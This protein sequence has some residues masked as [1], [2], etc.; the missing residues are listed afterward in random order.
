M[1]LLLSVLLGFIPMLLFAW[2]VYWLDRYEKEPAI[3]LGAVFLWGALVA[4]GAAFILNTLFGLGIYAFTGSESATDLTT[5]MLIAP[6]VEESVKGFAVLL[7]FL[8]FRSEFDSLLD[9]LIYA[10]VVALGFAASENAYYIYRLGFAENGMGGLIG[11][12]FVRVV[13][14][15]W[16]HPF[17]TAFI[18]IGLALARLNDNAN[19]K[20]AALAAGWV[21]AVLT[22]SI[23]NALASLLS[24]TGG[25]AVGTLIDWAG[26]VAMF[27]V[28]LWAINRERIY[29]RSYLKEELDLGLITPTQYQTASSAWSQSGARLAALFSGHYRQTARFYQ[30]CA[31]LAHKKNQL[32]R[33]GDEGGNAD[34]IDNLRLELGKLS[35]LV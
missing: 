31:E 7:V 17:Y 19:V 29:I 28:V 20:I 12:A 26:W 14:V 24:G 15:G 16:Q 30:A 34:I 3:L 23:H 35:K 1:G 25:L 18:G 8:I 2:F 6:V 9:G 5:G 22:H 13:L 33:L 21:A 4:A 32:I 10:A 27:L 11:M